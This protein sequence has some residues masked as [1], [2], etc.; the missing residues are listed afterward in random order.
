M[1]KKLVVLSLIILFTLTAFSEIKIN[2]SETS[3]VTVFNILTDYYSVEIEINDNKLTREE[4][5]DKN[6]NSVLK[7][8]AN[9][10]VNLMWTGWQAPDVINNSENPVEYDSSYFTF[11][12]FEINSS[13]DYKELKLIFRSRDLTLKSVLYYRFLKSKYYFRKKTGFFR[14]R[15]FK[16]G[17]HFLRK[18]YPIYYLSDKKDIVKSGGYGQPIGIISNAKGLFF[19]IEYPTA[20]NIVK[21]NDNNTIINCFEYIGEKI[22]EKPVFSDWSVI[23]I[24]PDKDLKKWFFKYLNDIRVV[25]LRPYLLYNTW[26]DLEAPVMVKN[27]KNILNEENIFRIYNLFKKIM[28]EKYNIKLNAFVIDDGWDIYK[29]DWKIDKNRFPNSMGY[30]SERLRKDNVNLGIWFGPIGG[31]SHRGWRIEWMKEN[32]YETVG[33]ELCF[34]GKNY[35]ELL[36]KRILDFVKKDKI[37]YFKW[38][39]FQFSCSEPDHGHPIGIFSRRYILENLIKLSNKTRKLN[40]N[41]YLNITSGTW[42]SPW[43]LKI[44]D[45]IWMQGYDYGYA[46]VPS[47]SQRDMAMTYRDYVLY[48]DFIKHNLWFP[49][50]NLMTHGIIKGDLQNLGGKK[51]PIDKFTNNVAFYFARGITMYELYITPDLLTENEWD[52]IAKSIKWAKENFD[53]L[54][55]Y[56]EMIGKN[57]GEKSPYGFIHF[58][59]DKGIIAIRNPYVNEENIEIEL[60]TEYDLSKN[61]KELVVERI[62]PNHYILPKLYKTGDKIIIKTLPYETSIYKLYPLKSAKKPLISGIVYN[63]K[64]INKTSEL[65][66]IYNKVGKIKILNNNFIKRIKKQN[67][68]INSNDLLKLD[69]KNKNYIKDIKMIQNENK[70]ILNLNLDKEILSPEIDILFEYTTIKQDKDIP[71]YKIKANDLLK[72]KIQANNRELEI[73]T[74]KNIGWTWYK[75]NIDSNTKRIEISYNN[76]KKVK[77]VLKLY[78]RY[79][80]SEKPIILTIK[81]RK[82]IKEESKLPFITN[83]LDFFFIGKQIL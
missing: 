10:K 31:Y 72:L 24:T 60:K 52:S 33:D 20:T 47:I 32:G 71:P 77:G 64:R 22:G 59:K 81:T 51:E 45:Q 70:I 17:K 83:N 27:K 4:Y 7:T 16:R 13:S 5:F 68:H 14:Y 53:I 6:H 56:T 19:A 42:L 39:G 54:S 73:K 25:K 79:L 80:K 37:G 26:Y 57:P 38:D 2:K 65:F 1:K 74:I 36:E 8:D 82:N 44:A 21:E 75:A 55:N 58:K 50:S 35:Y 76:L 46:G 67:K 23:G 34:G 63:S 78:L 18:I 48:E 40:K 28:F 30:I 9:Y 61:A 66:L 12:K 15:K 11:S 43:W 62:Y 69:F 29:S 49:I 3:N 41:I